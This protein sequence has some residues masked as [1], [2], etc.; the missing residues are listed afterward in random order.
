MAST[1]IKGNQMQLDFEPGVADRYPSLRECV[2]TCI[3]RKGL[4][5]VAA[6]LDQAPSNLSVQISAD[7]ARH[8]SV[9]S[10]EKFLHEYDDYTPIYYL[11]EKFLGDKQSDEDEDD[12]EL[13]R[14]IEDLLAKVSSR[15]KRRRAA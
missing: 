7:T 12:D 8:F 10:L 11:I 15:K 6:T 13:K 9:E 2:A 5:K 1:A 4:T 3:Y 14:Q